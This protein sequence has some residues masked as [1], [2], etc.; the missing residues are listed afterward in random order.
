MV[1]NLHKL[2]INVSHIYESLHASNC[3]TKCKLIDKNSSLLWHKHLGHIS[4]QRIQRLMSEGILDSLNF[5]NLKICIECIKRRQTN[6]KKV[7][8]NRS[9]SVLELIHTDIRGLFPMASWNGQHYFITFIYD[10]SHYGCLYLI[11]EKS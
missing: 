2:D 4:K 1:D 3:G 8:A 6:V 5:S 10:Y 11:H 7:S 9:S